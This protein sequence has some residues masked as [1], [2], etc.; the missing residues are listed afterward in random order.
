MGR[1]PQAFR[2][3]VLARALKAF[4]KAGVPVERAE[5]EPTGKITVFAGKPKT[6]D[7][8]LSADDELAR[9]RGKRH[10]DKG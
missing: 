6:E 9:W 4:T 3:R 10:A 2:E 5:V 8:S 1:G 7:T